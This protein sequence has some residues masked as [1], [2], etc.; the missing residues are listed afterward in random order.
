MKRKNYGPKL[1]FYPLPLVVVG[2]EVKGK[3]T[4]TTIAW[5]TPVEDEP[6][7]I[8]CAIAKDHYLL[9]QRENL[10]FYSLNFPSCDQVVEVDFCGIV[11]GYDYDKSK[12]FPI[13]YGVHNAPLVANAPLSLECQVKHWLDVGESCYLLIGEVVESYIEEKYI[14][15]GKPDVSSMKIMNY[16]TKSSEYRLVGDR[17]AK[18]REIGHNFK[19]GHE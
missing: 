18:A 15:N 7:L 10:E 17:V 9:S 19:R 1:W 4:F 14:Q 11:S 2:A 3:P 13:E 6:P 12:V 16:I 8:L 5:A